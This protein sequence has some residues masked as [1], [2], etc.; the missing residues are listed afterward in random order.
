VEI[1]QLAA[2]GTV[3][4][5]VVADRE[6]P[7]RLGV[8]ERLQPEV[9]LLRQRRDVLL[10]VRVGALVDQ[11]NARCA[12]HEP[13]R[14]AVDDAGIH[15]GASFDGQAEPEQ[16]FGSKG[17]SVAA[18]LTGASAV[19]RPERTSERLGRAVAVSH[20]DAQQIVLRPDHVGRGDGHAA[21][22]HVLRQRHASQRREHPAQVVFGRAERP[23]QTVD[24]ELLGEVLLDKADEPVEC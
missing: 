15:G 16:R 23:R 13:E 8:T 7:G 9:L 20:R 19:D 14:G 18:H 22:A 17:A 21:S 2:L 10:D 12:S 6:E 11:R 4:V 24:V 1:R 3:G 5:Q